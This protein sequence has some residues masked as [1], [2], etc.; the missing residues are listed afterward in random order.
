MADT[1]EFELV[2]PERLLLSQP[3]EMVVVPGAEGDFG[4]LPGHA[5]VISAVRPGVIS[6]YEDGKVAARIFV[7]G[8]FAE[9]TAARCTVLADEAVELDGE[10]A[11][12]ASARLAKAREAQSIADTDDERA[13]AEAE[14]AIAEAFLAAAESQGRA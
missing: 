8:G 2:S 11:A 6:T 14:L 4:V 7:A 10:A 13:A 9:V 12:A 5:P 1:V 3:V